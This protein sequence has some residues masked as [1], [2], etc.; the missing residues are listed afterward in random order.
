MFRENLAEEIVKGQSMRAS[1]GLRVSAARPYGYDLGENLAMSINEEEAHTVRQIFDLFNE[2]HNI[3]TITGMLNDLGVSKKW[4]A[5]TVS[6]ILSNPTYIGVNHWK[7]KGAIDG[8][9]FENAHEAIIPEEVFQEAQDILLK[10]KE[11]FLSQSST[12]FIFSTVV[13]CGV[14]GRSFSGRTR[15]EKGRLQ[16]DYRCSGKDRFGCKVGSIAN[17]KLTALFLD[18]IDNFNLSSNEP[19]K[20]L[21]GRDLSKERKRLEKMLSDSANVTKNY[22]RAF[23]TGKIEFDMFTE[24]KTEE[25]KKCAEWSTELDVINQMSP[26]DKKTRKDI[27]ALLDNLK[28]DWNRISELDRKMSI[29]RIF[30]FLVIKRVEGNW[31]IVAFK[32][33]D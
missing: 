28:S 27:V 11:H 33:H 3:L 14:C 29:S 13:K 16:L 25:D 17:S 26:S 2:G 7:R 19:Q 31:K 24:L 23:G 10:R 6:R 30:K 9:Y 12:N 5:V 15:R 18:F 20:I 4:H 21:A 22:L 8:I 32:T 1:K